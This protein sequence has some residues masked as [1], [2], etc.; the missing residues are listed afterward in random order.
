MIY[1]CF[2]EHNNDD[3]LLYSLDY[4][5][6]YTRG[7]SLKEA[8]QKMPDEIRSFILW[9]GHTCLDEQISIQVIEEKNSTLNIGDADSDAIFQCETSPL[10]P[11][12]YSVLKRLAL[13]SAEDFFSLYNSIP[14]KDIGCLPNRETFYGSVPRTATEMYEHT[15]N[16]NNYY[17]GEIGIKC[18]NDGDIVACRKRGFDLLEKT[19]DFLN[20][21]PTLG[22]YDETWSLKK[23]FRR[24]IWHDRIHAKAMYRMAIKL[25]GSDIPDVFHFK[26]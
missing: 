12:E 9:S 24:F 15:K 8:M 3:T 10:K 23:C 17:F 13:K 16:V 21:T 5:G 19:S 2:W 20:N 22:S 7:K 11:E 1:N 26:I 18:D 25:F 6:A 14:N 4:P